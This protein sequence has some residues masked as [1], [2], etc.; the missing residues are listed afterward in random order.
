LLK[1]FLV[2]KSKVTGCSKAGGREKGE[3]LPEH[4]GG[5]KY[6]LD[7]SFTE[8]SHFRQHQFSQM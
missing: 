8:W 3:D 5:K 7:I 1:I 6:D 4:D 2:G